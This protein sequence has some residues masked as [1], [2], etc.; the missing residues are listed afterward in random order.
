VPS[1]IV[2]G[3]WFYRTPVV[4]GDCVPAWCGHAG[5]RVERGASGRTR[6]CSRPLRAR[7]RW[8]FGSFGGALA[9]ADGQTV[10]PPVMIASTKK[11]CT[12]TRDHH[13]RTVVDLGTHQRFVEC[14]G[15]G[16]P[17]IRLEAGGGQSCQT[18]EPI[19]PALTSLTR[20]CRYDRAG[21]GPSTPGPR[22]T[23]CQQLAQDLQ[24]VLQT[25][26]I[27]GPYLL[28]SHSFGSFIARVYA[29]EHPDQIVGSLLLDPNHEAIFP[30][31]VEFYTQ[32]LDQL[33]LFGN[34]RPCP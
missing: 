25:A 24:T 20:A 9:A 28:V 10:R 23:S 8:L 12:V 34:S 22:P 11:E 26:G 15:T 30:R 7:D 21:V 14:A 17:T 16:V 31:W 5:G 4:P 27:P 18:W 1:V 3:M 6:P 32:I 13:V 19:W 33:R 29:H 2:C